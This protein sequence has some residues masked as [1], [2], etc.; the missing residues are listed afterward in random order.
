MYGGPGMYPLPGCPGWFTNQPP[1][2]TARTADAYVIRYDVEPRSYFRQMTAIGPAFGANLAETPRFESVREANHMIDRFGLV[3]G[4]YAEVELL[5]GRE[6][7]PGRARHA[8]RRATRTT[9]KRA[10]T[11]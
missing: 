9:N 2:G 8:G 11:P 7:P 5:P 1:L 6:S 10:K 3:A 4:V